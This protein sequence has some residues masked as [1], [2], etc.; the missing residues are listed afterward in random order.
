MIYTLKEFSNK[1]KINNKWVSYKTIE[2]MARNGLLPSVCKIKKL[3][4]KTGARLIEVVE[5]LSK[6]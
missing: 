5:I 4:G 2:R 3:P 1:F 6:S